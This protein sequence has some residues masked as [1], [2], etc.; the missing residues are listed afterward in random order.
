MTLRK[1]LLFRMAP[2]VLLPFV[3]AIF[4]T[5]IRSAAFVVSAVIWSAFVALYTGY[6]L[7]WYR[8]QLVAQIEK[9]H[10]YR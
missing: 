10:G 2:L 3:L 8:R 7:N 1:Q 6:T 9:K 5:D 4:I